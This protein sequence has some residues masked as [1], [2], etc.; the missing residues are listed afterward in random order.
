MGSINFGF[1]IG[2]TSP[3]VPFFLKYWNTPEIQTTF[4]NAILSV[5]AMVGPYIAT[6]ML[7]YLGRRPVFCI[8]QFFSGVI[9]LLM[10]TANQTHFW[11]LILMRALMGLAIGGIASTGPT[12]LVEVAPEGLSG[13]FGNLAQTGICTGCIIVY[14]AG[15]WTANVDKQAYKWWIIPII[16]AA[17]N[18][19]SCLLIWICP[20][21]GHHAM[22]ADHEEIGATKESLCQKKYLGKLFVGVMLM[23]IQQFS[24][25]N[26]IVTNL[27]DNLRTSKVPMDSGIAS[28]I[29]MFMMVI[30]VFIGGMLIDKLGRK[31]LFTASCLECGITLI[32]YACCYNYDWPS[33]IALICICLYLFL[34]G[35]ALGPVPW[36]C[37]PE[38]FPANLRSLGNSIVSTT[39]QL[40]TFVV[41]FIFPIMT[42]KKNPDTGKFSG[43]MGYMAGS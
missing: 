28:A 1:T 15:N 20:E 33:W 12:M 21:T 18:F 31:L 29:S 43:G 17:F 30:A 40:F 38:L 11:I 24:G 3:L 7:K 25:I 42:G 36:Y 41:I 23:I 6:F 5:V 39:N 26:A 27:D 8:L 9:Y 14:L 4:F 2:F 22:I 32:V 10:L 35:V 19:L 16:T 37:I 13:F 34:F